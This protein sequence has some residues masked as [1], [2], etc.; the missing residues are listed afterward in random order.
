ME[1]GLKDWFA[2]ADGGELRAAYDVLKAAH[3]QGRALTAESPEILAVTEAIGKIITNRAEKLDAIIKQKNEEQ[4]QDND[5]VKRMVKGLLK[6]HYLKI[7]W[8]LDH[9]GSVYLKERTLQ[10]DEK[11]R[12]MNDRKARHTAYVEQTFQS[13][14]ES[15]LKKQLQNLENAAKDYK[16]GGVKEKKEAAK[17]INEALTKIVK[18]LTSDIKFRPQGKRLMKSLVEEYENDPKVESIC[19]ILTESDKYI[20]ELFLDT[21]F[22]D[23]QNENGAERPSKFE[24]AYGDATLSRETIAILRD[25]RTERVEGDQPPLA[26]R[27][28]NG[29]PIRWVK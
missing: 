1:N 22:R 5:E 9:M 29:E 3:A 15:G 4:K 13:L 10:E 11:N 17:A 12:L 14:E 25:M 6:E 2:D 21:A 26:E 20:R 16:I 7:L 8:R 23:P 18:A 24:K 27:L 28:R 19:Q